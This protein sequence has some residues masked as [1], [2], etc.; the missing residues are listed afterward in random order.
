PRVVIHAAN[1]HVGGGVQVA[2][3]F[4]EEVARLPLPPFRLEV[5]AS[6]EV[7]AGLE[8]LGVDCGRFDGFETLDVHGP[9]RGMA[10]LRRRLA[11]ADA[12]FTLFGPSYIVPKPRLSI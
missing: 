8:R 11:G 4:L 7:A 3:S 10:A 12:V 9:W 1:L 6:S 2:T 5:L